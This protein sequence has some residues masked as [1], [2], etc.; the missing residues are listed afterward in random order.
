MEPGQTAISH[1]GHDDQLAEVQLLK[2]QRELALACLI[3]SASISVAV[4]WS[5]LGGEPKAIGDTREEVAVHRKQ[6]QQH[7][8]LLAETQKVLAEVEAARDALLRNTAGR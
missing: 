5:N 7:Q 3:L 4:L 8:V 1:A 2:E 6:F